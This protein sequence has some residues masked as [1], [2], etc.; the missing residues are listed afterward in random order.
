MNNYPPGVTGFE[1]QI[2]G[3]DEVESVREVECECG[4]L[5]EVPTV[6]YLS[7][8]EVTWYAEWILSLIHI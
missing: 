1:P 3:Y 7:M 4:W 2:A 6:E 5:G 8:G